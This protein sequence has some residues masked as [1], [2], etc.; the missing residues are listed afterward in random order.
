MNV[1]NINIIY[2]IDSCIYALYMKRLFENFE[3]LSRFG[4]A[5]SINVLASVDPFD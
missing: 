3:I 1:Q 5:S 2:D 4:P